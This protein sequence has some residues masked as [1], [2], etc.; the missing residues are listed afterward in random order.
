MALEDVLPHSRRLI[1]EGGRLRGR[2]LADIWN[3]PFGLSAKSQ[4]RQNTSQYQ[5]NHIG[6]DG[7]GEGDDD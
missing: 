4:I 6:K 1:K 7:D 3:S 5:L 2:D